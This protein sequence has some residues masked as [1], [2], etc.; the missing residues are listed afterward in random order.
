MVSEL[1]F[2]SMALVTRRRGNR[3]ANFH[4][5]YESAESIHEEPEVTLEGHEEDLQAALRAQIEDLT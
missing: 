5:A 3:Y 4:D 1:S 2:L